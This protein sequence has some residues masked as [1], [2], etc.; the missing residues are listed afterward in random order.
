MT[1]NDAIYKTKGKNDECYTPAYV[2]KEIIPYIPKGWK[3]WCPFDTEDSEFVK[4]LSRNGYNVL[5]SHIEYGQDFYKYKPDEYFDCIISNP[6][7]SNKREIFERAISFNK[8]FLLLMTAQ[9]LNDAAPVQLFL[10][11][12]IPM[13]IVHFTKRIQFKNCENKIPF[14]SIFIGTGFP[15]KYDNLLI[16]L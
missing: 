5:F 7:F 4:V 16:N 13:Q 6:P 1:I 2:V 9:W 15:F 3:I 10:K 12:N 14:K 8:P 11:H